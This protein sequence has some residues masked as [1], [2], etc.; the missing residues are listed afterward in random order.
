MGV[1]G[2]DTSCYRTSLAFTEDGRILS[3]RR[4][5][6]TVKPGE[7]GLRQSEGLFQHVQNLPHLVEEVRRDIGERKAQAVAVSI[8][9]RGVEGSY[10]PV[11]TAG[12]AFA[13]GISEMLSVPFFETN[14]QQGHIRAALYGLDMEKGAFLAVHM[15]GGTTE[16]LE[17]GEGLSVR[18]IGGSKDLHAG[19]LVDRVGVKLGLSFPSGPEMELLAR[20][21][22]S[23]SLLKASVRGADCNLSG[24]E[25]EIMRLIEG[26]MTKEDAAAEVYSFLARTL[27]KMLL[28]AASDTGLKRVLLAGGVC[29]SAILKEL[30]A[31]RIQRANGD[32]RLHWAQPEYSGDNAVG[33]AL[34]GEDRLRR[35]C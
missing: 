34:I 25:A 17:A 20:D 12:Y 4:M 33:V 2:I 8:A 31:E 18:L 15:S 14:H 10:M 21:G 23:K 5:L 16:V 11:F 6:L 22:T 26:G 19:Q 3:D 35:H 30:L 7:R 9:P 28:N 24:A 27:A 29:S 13:K 32:L 1:L